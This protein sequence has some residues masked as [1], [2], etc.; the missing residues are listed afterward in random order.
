MAAPRPPPP[1]LR[2][3][4]RYNAD[5]MEL[6]PGDYII[7]N[8][9]GR[10]RCK[11]YSDPPHIGGHYIC[12]YEMGEV[13]GPIK[14]VIKSAEFVTVLVEGG[15]YINVERCAGPDGRGGCKFARRVMPS[16]L[17]RFRA[18]GLIAA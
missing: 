13:I 11:A 16:E 3:R 7:T 12:T 1:N 14:V 10:A 17:L 5:P 15:E 18:I 9:R 2:R 6:E 4:R 8:N